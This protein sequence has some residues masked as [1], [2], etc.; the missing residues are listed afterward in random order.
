MIG[1]SGAIPRN[2]LKEM[3]KHAALY[4]EEI[5]K[6]SGDIESIAKNTGFSIDDV[7]IVKNHVF[8]N[9]YNL[10]GKKL[11]R[12]D[13]DYDMAVSWQRL[14]EGI[15]IKEM[16]IVL[17]HHEL[18]EYNFMNKGMNY[19]EAHRIAE[20]TYNYKKYADELDKIF[21]E[22]SVKRGTPNE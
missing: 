7:E 2:N 10:D 12:F 22:K 21:K 14:I 9:Q 16:D 15:N 20:K 5:R 8:F 19:D 11:K 6:R 18:M 1:A 17:L 3:D 13:P 4:Y